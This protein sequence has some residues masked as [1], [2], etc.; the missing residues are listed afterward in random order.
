MLV[1]PDKRAKKVREDDV[2]RRLQAKK[3]REDDVRRRL[4]FWKLSEQ[5]TID[6]AH[7]VETTTYNAKLTETHNFSRTHI[8]I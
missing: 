4:Q 7:K 5:Q 3:A 2:R 1:D 8:D 6:S